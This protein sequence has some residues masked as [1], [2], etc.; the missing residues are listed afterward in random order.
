MSFV[1]KRV[2]VPIWGVN[3]FRNKPNS[4]IFKVLLVSQYHW[5]VY[6]HLEKC[7]VCWTSIIHIFLLFY[8]SYYYY[9]S[10]LPILLLF[11]LHFI[12]HFLSNVMRRRRRRYHTMLFKCINFI[13]HERYRYLLSYK[14]WAST[15]S[16]QSKIFMWYINTNRDDMMSTYVLCVEWN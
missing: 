12:I 10:S 3:R 6:S 11:I 15:K 8:S 7:N 2:K 9:L 14:Y 4:Q 13:K 5:L 1:L 16:K